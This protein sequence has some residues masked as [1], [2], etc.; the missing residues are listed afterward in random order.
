MKGTSFQA[1]QI[2]SDFFSQMLSH[3][4]LII[5]SLTSSNYCFI[6]F[7]LFFI[8][9]FKT[10]VSA[11]RAQSWCDSKNSIPYFETSAKESINVE[12]A[13]Q[14]IA[15]NALAQEPDD[16]TYQDFPSAIKIDS[17]NKAK[18]EGCACWE[19]LFLPHIFLTTLL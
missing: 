4:E 14:T 10:Q 16:S 13:F 9:L 6:Y 2:I 8:F 12:Q 17:D 5:S 19:F 18:S 1:F 3:P 7:F 11:K 15:K